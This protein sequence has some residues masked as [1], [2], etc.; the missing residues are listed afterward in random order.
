MKTSI[1]LLR[2]DFTNELYELTKAAVTTLKADENILVDNGSTIGEITDWADVYVK[3]KVNKG[4]TRGVNQGF[5]LATGDLLAVANNDIL[6]SSNAISIA[7]EIFK[8]NPKVGS[9][10]YRMQ[11]YEEPFFFGFDTWISG[12]E[13]WCH[14]SFYVIRREAV[15]EGM[16]F[17]GY[18]EGG[19]DDYDFWTRVRDINGWKQ[20][21]TNKAS[22]RH[23]DSSTYIALDKRDGTRAERDA[24]NREIYK[25]RFGKDPDE[26]FAEKF[27]G[28]LKEDWK[29]FP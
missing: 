9:V 3:N 20:A 23:K 6:V 18:E 7:E 12:K 21:Y 28:Q 22:F 26:W 10:H 1:I 25:K 24:R 4:Y 16:Y 5:K 8:E 17:E 14:S 27:L 2:C 13:R 29:P 15:P 11:P 19:F